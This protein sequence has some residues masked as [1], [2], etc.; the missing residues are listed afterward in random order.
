MQVSLLL[1]RLRQRHLIGHGERLQQIAARQIPVR[2]FPLR[3][4]VPEARRVNASISIGLLHLH[5]GGVV[6]L[7]ARDISPAHSARIRGNDLLIVAPC[8]QG[9]LVFQLHLSLQFTNPPRKNVVTRPS[10]INYPGNS[11][12]LYP[13]DEG[14]CRI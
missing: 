8:G 2:E 6:V 9:F 11:P 14:A 5:A 7:P 12:A 4:A 1:P 10:S 3:P 13:H